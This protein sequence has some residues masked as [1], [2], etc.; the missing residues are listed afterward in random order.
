M[1]NPYQK[2]G[3]N[4]PATTTGATAWFEARCRSRLTMTFTIRH[5]EVTRGTRAP[6]DYAASMKPPICRFHMRA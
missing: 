3:A 4:Y 6:K 1:G 5:P 2:P